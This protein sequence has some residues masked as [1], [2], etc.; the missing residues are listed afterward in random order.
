MAHAIRIKDVKK[1]CVDV[2]QVIIELSKV[3]EREETGKISEPSQSN[4][5]NKN[6]LKFISK[7]NGNYIQELVPINRVKQNLVYMNFAV[8]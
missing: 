7:N 2:E 4:D 6:L 1:N 3:F 5:L 8:Y